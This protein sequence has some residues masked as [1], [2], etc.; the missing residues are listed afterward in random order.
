MP[1]SDARSVGHTDNDNLFLEYGAGCRKAM[2]G[3][4]VTLIMII[5]LRVCSK[6]PES[7]ARSVGQF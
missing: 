3:V 1:E 2:L 4:W 6:V 7:D 5:F